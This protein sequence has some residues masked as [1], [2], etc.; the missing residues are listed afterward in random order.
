V[1]GG[2]EVAGLIERVEA[3][4]R[5]ILGDLGCDLYDLEFSGGAL[6]IVVDQPGG[7]DLETIAL[8]TRLISREL[9][10]QDPIDSGY[11]LEVSSPGLERILR[12]PDHFTRLV[13]LGWTLNV[14]SHPQVDGERRV[15][16]VL[17]AADDDTFTIR[18]ADTTDRTYRYGDVERV[19]SVVDWAPPPKASRPGPARLDQTPA[20]STESATTTERKRTAP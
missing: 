13:G 19:K 20:T 14:K 3:L 6:R 17:I 15:K 10:A 5:P 11:T 18:L 12:R 8:A 1:R 4:A 9:D 7:V 2:V 16:G